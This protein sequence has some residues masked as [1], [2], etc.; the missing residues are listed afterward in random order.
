VQCHE[1]GAASFRAEP[2]KG[3]ADEIAALAAIDILKGYFEARGNFTQAY[4]RR[5]RDDDSVE[6]RDILD[7]VTVLDMADGAPR[8]LRDFQLIASSRIH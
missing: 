6:F 8:V 2:D 7:A 1:S 5:Y 4:F 3:D